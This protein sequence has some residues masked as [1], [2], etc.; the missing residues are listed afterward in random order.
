MGR[1]AIR[2]E[3]AR[4]FRSLAAPTG[5]RAPRLRSFGG[6]E[7]IL[8]AWAPEGELAARSARTI[9]GIVLAIAKVLCLLISFSEVSSGKMGNR[10]VCSR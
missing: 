4:P 1:G 3:V 2:G 7:A 10:N 5:E 6:K 8:P 9:K